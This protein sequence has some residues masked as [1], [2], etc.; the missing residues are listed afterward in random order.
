MAT[1]LAALILAAVSPLGG[2]ATLYDCHNHAHSVTCRVAIVDPTRSTITFNGTN[3]FTLDY[4]VRAR[5]T[6]HGWKLTIGGVA[7]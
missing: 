7:Q 6:T 3:H 1:P 2:T 5:M 4:G